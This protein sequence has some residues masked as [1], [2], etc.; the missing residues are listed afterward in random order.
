MW[1]LTQ[2]I[3]GDG[4]PTP[5]EQCEWEL[6]QTISGNGDPTKSEEQTKKPGL[7]HVYHLTFGCL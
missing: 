2:T 4:D 5:S 7:P 1:Q 6:T 3:S